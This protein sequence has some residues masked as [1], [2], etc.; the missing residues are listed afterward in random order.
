MQYVCVQNTRVATT[1]GVILFVAG[2]PR[3][4]PDILLN[5]AISLGARPV[6]EVAEPEP[7][8]KKTSKT[9]KSKPSRAEEVLDAV[10]QTYARGKESEFTRAGIPKTAVISRVAGFSVNSE[11]VAEAIANMPVGT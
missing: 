8:P 4:V 10:V 11:M 1:M 6:S 3:H 9:K 2:I 7:E 5:E